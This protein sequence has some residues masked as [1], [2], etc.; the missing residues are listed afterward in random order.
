[1]EVSDVA[2]APD[3]TGTLAVGPLEAGHRRV[4]IVAGLAPA[5]LEPMHFRVTFERSGG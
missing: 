1:M 5:T 2:V 3:T 4:L